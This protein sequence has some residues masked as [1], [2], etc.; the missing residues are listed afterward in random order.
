MERG[1]T[2][3]IDLEAWSFTRRK[4]GQSFKLDEIPAKEKEI[5]ICRGIV[6]ISSSSRPRRP[7]GEASRGSGIP[8]GIKD[9]TKRSPGTGAYQVRRF[10]DEC[11]I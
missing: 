2:L 10:P 6:P 5:I 3:E 7:R 1:E 4:T 8:S 9:G 11:T